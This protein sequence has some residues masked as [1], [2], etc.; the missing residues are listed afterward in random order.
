MSAAGEEL[1]RS[2][3]LLTDPEKRQIASEIIRRAFASTVEVDESQLAD[4][5]S[6]SADGDRKL[7]EHGIED[8]DSGLLIEDD[9][10]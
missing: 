9:A 2:F 8:Y 6:E 4:L 10:Q 7:A 3:D 1:L 5:Y